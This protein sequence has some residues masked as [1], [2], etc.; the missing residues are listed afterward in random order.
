MI[1]IIQQILIADFF[2]RGNCLDICNQQLSYS[3]CINSIEGQCM[4]DSVRN[5]CQHT[6]DYMQGCSTFLNLL[7]CQK[8]LGDALGQFAKCRFKKFCENIPDV[9]TETCYNNLSKYG[10]LS[11]QNPKQICIWK[12]QKCYFLGTS[13]QSSLIQNDFD[14]M[15]YSASACSLIEHYLVI[16]SSL[17]WNLTSYIPDLQLEAFQQQQRDLNIIDTDDINFDDPSLNEMQNNYLTKNGK[18]IW[19]KLGKSLQFSQTNLQIS[20]RFREGCIALEIYDDDDFYSI[21]SVQGE[22][23]GVNHVYCKYL[24]QNPQINQKYIFIDNK[25]VKFD[26]NELA[27]QRIIEEYNIN[28]KSL[29]KY[30]CIFFN[31]K[32]YNC[33]IEDDQNEYQCVEV[34]N[35]YEIDCSD[36]FCT[37]KQCQKLDNHYI[38]LGTNMCVNT[39]TSISNM[40]EC[41]SQDCNYLGVK[42]TQSEIICAPINICNQIGLTKSGCIFLRAKCDWD[43]NENKCYELQDN[44]IS[45]MKCSDVQNLHVCTLISLSDQLCYWSELMMKCINILDQPLLMVQTIFMDRNLDENYQQQ[46]SLVCNLNLCKYNSL[47]A[48]EFDEVK[49]VCLFDQLNLNKNLAL[50]NK[51]DCLHNFKGYYLW[52]Q[53][54]QI[55]QKFEQS[56]IKNQYCLELVDV[57]ERFC[58]YSKLSSITVR[59]VYDQITTSCIEKTEN[60]VNILGCSGNGLSEEKC[61]NNNIKGQFCTYQDEL[62]MEVSINTINNLKCSS[63]INVN[64]QICRMYFINK[65]LCKYNEVTHSCI[66]LSSTDLIEYNYNLNRYACQAVSDSYTYFDEQIN[67]CIEFDSTSDIYLMKLKCEEKYVNKL[68]C[69]SIITDGQLCIWS[70]SL[71]QCKN[72][73]DNFPSCS[74]FENGSSQT[75]VKLKNMNKQESTMENYCVYQDNKCI[76]K[77][78]NQ[79][80]CG[81]EDIMNIHRCSGMTGIDQDGYFVQMCAF[82]AKKCITLIDSS[83]D[84]EIILNTITCEQANQKSC[85]QVKT[86]GQFCYIT[87]SSDINN[88][89]INKGCRFQKLDKK[90]CY[91]LNYKYGEDINLLNPKICS[92]ATDECI[93]DSAEGCMSI[94]DTTLNYDCE[95]PGIS[96]KLCISQTKERRC[97]FIDKTCKYISENYVFTKDCKYLNE[98]ACSSSPF[99]QCVWNEYYMECELMSFYYIESIT[100]DYFCSSNHDNI[101]MISGETECIEIDQADYNLYTCD[102]PGLN[103]YGCYSIPTQ[104]CQ[105]LNNKC[106][107]YSSVLCDD[108]TFECESNDT[109]D[110]QCVFKD[111][112][113]F[114]ITNTL[115]DCDSF[116]KT[117]YLFC[118]QYPNCI[119]KDSQCQQIK[120][121][122]KY[123]DCQSIDNVTTCTVQNSEHQ[124][125]YIEEC[126][127]LDQLLDICPSLS[128]YYSRSVCS[129][130][131]DCQ[132]GYTKNGFGFCF[133]G[134]NIVELTC[135]QLPQDLCLSDLSH[136]NGDLTCFWDS[137]EE[138]CRNV[139]NYNILTCDDLSQYKSSYA[140]CM[141]IGNNDCKYSFQ[142][143]KCKL[144]NEYFGTTCQGSTKQQC[145]QIESICY[146]KASTCV[147]S[148]TNDQINKYGCIHQTGYYKYHQGSCKLLE[149]TDYQQSCQNL[150]KDACLSE[151][152]KEIHCRWINE[153][154]K[155]VLIQENKEISSCSDLNQRVCL[156]VALS[157]IQCKWNSE[158]KSCETIIITQFD[159]TLTDQTNNTSKSLCSGQTSNYCVRRLDGTECSPATTKINSCV[160]FGLNLNACV[161]LTNDVPCIWKQYNNGGYCENA[162]LYQSQC[163]DLLNEKACMNVKNLGQHCK[164]DIDQKRCQFQEITT[165]SSASYLNGILP[166]KAVSEELCQYDE[167]FNQCKKIIDTLTDCSELYNQQACIQSSKGCVWNLNSCKC[168]LFL[169]KFVCLNNQQVGCQWVDNQCESFESIYQ[170]IYCVNLPKGLNKFACLTNAMDPCNLNFQLEMCLPSQSFSQN[171]DDYVSVSQL[172]EIQTLDYP[173][174][175]LFNQCEQ[176]ETKHDCIHSRKEDQP[177][178][179]IETCQ[180]VTNFDKLKCSDALNIWGCLGITS[181]NQLCF[182]NHK[183][184]NWNQDNPIMS[185]VNINVCINHS[186]SSIYSKNSCQVKDLQTIDCTSVGISKL[187]CLSIPNQPCQWI[188]SLNQCQKFVQDNKKNKCSDYQLV[189]P[190]VCQMLSDYACIHDTDTFSCITTDQDN[191]MIGLSKLACLQNNQKPVYWNETNYC[192]DLKIQITCDSKLQV[193]S[194]ACQSISDT[195]CLYNNKLNQCISQFN[196]WSLTC[197]AAG[198]N[199]HACSMVLQEPCIF[200]NN[201]C[202]K[203][204]DYQSS[205]ITVKNVNALACA[206]IINENCIYD[207][208]KLQCNVPIYQSNTCNV[209]GK[210]KMFCET[211]SLCNWSQEKLMCTCIEFQSEICKFDKINE[212]KANSNCYFNGNQCTRKQCYHLKSEDC[213]SI[214]DDKQCYLNNLNDCQSASRCEDIIDSKLP[215]SNY[216]INSIQCSQAGNQC[217]SSNNLDLY[218]PYSDCSNPKCKYQ[219]GICK[220]RTCSDYSIKDCNGVGG[221]YLD[222][223]KICQILSS[224][225]LVNN[226]GESAM[227]ICNQ[228]SVQGFRCNWQKM[229][230]LDSIEVCTSQP[231]QLYGSSKSLCHGNEIN[232]YS[233]IL[234]NSLICSQCEQIVE[235]CQCENQQQICSYANGKCVSIL[236]SSFLTKVECLQAQDRCYWSAQLK[237]DNSIVEKCVKECIK[238]I[239][240]D[241]CTSR[242]KECYYEPLQMKCMK[243]QK[244]VIDLSTDI[245]IEE[246]Y[247]H[248][249]ST[250][251][252]IFILLS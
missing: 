198:L 110:Q 155:T 49:R 34:Q 112:Q 133:Q 141:H 26:T 159:C 190:F 221:C 111:G 179:W 65:T 193:N 241:E 245:I 228:L 57:N 10:C 136:L 162:N 1:F 187:T 196:V 168:E 23:L 108:T 87:K 205:C 235:K 62:C 60:E 210:N 140:A 225:S 158:I 183:C 173:Q 51:Y 52:N 101:F 32:E 234:S 239:D 40:N 170:K 105:Y 135:E 166:C 36:A 248:V 142:D 230:L 14:K 146:F 50:I 199:L 66:E 201:K 47:L 156:E 21:F 116:E 92:Q 118:L 115:F 251:I 106:Q 109:N 207:S 20:N 107:F 89:I 53:E 98:F 2:L 27:N 90:Y 70:T 218:C 220:V 61:L 97:A 33:Q 69:L 137:T 200:R 83:M 202:Q 78:E 177:C 100:S 129:N 54:K 58:Q 161:E 171:F 223:N 229:S 18:F 16:H 39:C 102:T 114:A 167:L 68:T 189:S 222:S 30:Q 104:Y 7:A 153:K 82:V 252:L 244:Q 154:C 212:C 127:S 28:C 67:R 80:D 41:L 208:V 22:I 249:M 157:N 132:Y 181:T 93:Y 144:V 75:C 11:V 8:Q 31:P 186:I 113:C 119:Y 145:D 231:C 45:L 55:C 121:Y 86:P 213:N 44:A 149:S 29:D 94:Y 48:T 138:T 163:S 46:I 15:M 211:N 81:D 188:A 184:L 77:I 215:C 147:K 99:I 74:F 246:F 151:L 6:N 59:C 243:G 232:G 63:L 130:F 192:E 247:S 13:S 219:F 117:N 96:Y 203:F 73:F 204:N 103:K 56:Q 17:L 38:D 37:I 197:D 85:G 25:C 79:I 227:N 180:R 178:V 174:P 242:S 43:N 35:D 123:T 206:S 217:A 125:Q 195:P 164:W 139:Q 233:C 120:Q 124:C 91:L 71:N 143:N 9:L 160:L 169:N 24:N 236:C 84:T 12:N 88:I 128:G 95:Q 238:I 72:Y 194:I 131:Q 209:S 224:C 76:S 150:S 152:T 19:Y 182:W 5:H 172:L 191:Q 134:Q 216:V 3:S 176:F 126:D 250:L 175:L 64:E 185:N 4:W 214:L 237:E 165:C 148:G 240:S 42:S 226:Y 122:Q